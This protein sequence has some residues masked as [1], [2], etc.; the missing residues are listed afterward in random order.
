MRPHLQA[1]RLLAADVDRGGAIAH[2]QYA[3]DGNG[4]RSSA[5][6][7]GDPALS[8]DVRSSAKYDAAGRIS[9]Y[10]TDDAATTYTRDGLGR[11]VGTATQTAT[12]TVAETWAFDGLTAVA[13]RSG[14]DTMAV[15]RDQLGT[16]GLGF[17]STEVHIMSTWHAGIEFEQLKGVSAACYSRPG[18]I[19]AAS[20]LAFLLI[21]VICGL[22]FDESFVDSPL[23]LLVIVPALIS[24]TAMGG[25]SAGYEVRL[26]QEARAGYATVYGRSVDLVEVDWLSSR[27]IRL[28]S[29]PR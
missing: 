23:S 12:G 11:A 27:V 15:I 25:Y 3:V 20:F 28:A 2:A 19:W 14:D 7:T 17:R 6:G 10:A 21:G 1:H 9:S 4:A 29:E 22:I 16:L 26:K 8:A 24:G 5:S 13:G 18:F